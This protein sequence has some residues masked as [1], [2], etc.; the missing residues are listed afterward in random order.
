MCVLS[1]S[2]KRVCPPDTSIRPPSHNGSRFLKPLI[3]TR[4]PSSEF[5]R[6]AIV[7]MFDL[8][9]ECIQVVT[10]LNTAFQLC[11]I[12]IVRPSIAGSVSV[13]ERVDDPVITAAT[14]HDKDPLPHVR[15]IFSPV[16]GSWAV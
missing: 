3:I 16:V 11:L 15:L 9:S 5:L 13:L 4:P 7:S 2:Q 10:T 1:F 12:I 8:S 6:S 14:P